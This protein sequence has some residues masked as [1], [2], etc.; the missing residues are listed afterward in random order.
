MSIQP[1]SPSTINAAVQDRDPA[2]GSSHTPHIPVEGSHHLEADSLP[3]YVRLNL[4]ESFFTE[5]ITN[6]VIGALP[7][8]YLMRLEPHVL[9]SLDPRK[10]DPS[11][12]RQQW[13]PFPP[14][15]A[16]SLTEEVYTAC[17]FDQFATLTHEEQEKLR[18]LGPHFIN[19]H[20]S[21]LQYIPLKKFLAFNPD[22]LDK[23]KPS[24]LD[25]MQPEV[26]NLID[27]AIWNKFTDE[28]FAVLDAPF[29]NKLGVEHI[30]RLTRSSFEHLCG[31][32]KTTAEKAKVLAAHTQESLKKNLQQLPERTFQRRQEQE[33]SRKQTAYI[34]AIGQQAISFSL[35]GAG[36]LS[37]TGKGLTGL[38]MGQSY[39]AG[40][41][42]SAGFTEA[43]KQVVQAAATPLVPVIV[44]ACGL[45]IVANLFSIARQMPTWGP[46][47][48]VALGTVAVAAGA[49]VALF[50]PGAAGVLG[51]GLATTTAGSILT[52][53][54]ARLGKKIWPYGRRLWHEI[55]QR[56]S[57]V[58]ETKRPIPTVGPLRVDPSVV[59][60][61]DAAVQDCTRAFEATT[62]A[63]ERVQ[64]VIADQELL[65][66]S[67][68]A[69]ERLQ[70]LMDKYGAREEREL[71]TKIQEKCTEMVAL[72]HQTRNANDVLLREKGSLIQQIERTLPESEQ[73]RDL[74]GPFPCSNTTRWHLNRID[75][76]LRLIRLQQQNLD[77]RLPKLFLQST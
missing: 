4:P 62:E 69:S 58:W 66:H 9:Q 41:L 51:I 12:M 8:Q 50:A 29:L 43:G 65:H 33:E 44:G 53:P 73:K 55:Q 54:A 21:Q 22:V 34:G 7:E 36:L 14:E 6:E 47:E 16:N 63:I 27:P 5:M 30:G 75:D 64:S 74:R 1:C 56:T 25:D 60:T 10:W 13:I 32:S 70:M 23:L 39:V 49:G 72:I 19:N 38:K 35:L 68:H 17:S 42:T 31:P 45:T 40:G 61:I 67:D 76:R 77:E 71:A 46:E 11:R 59:T 48:Y 28:M 3:D 24:V 18:S 15:F 37:A 26:R 20:A 2:L 52:L 57:R